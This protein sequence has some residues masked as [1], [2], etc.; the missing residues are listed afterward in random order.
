M[1]DDDDSAV[2]NMKGQG[3]SLGR[4]LGKQLRGA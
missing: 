2:P 4:N 1:L 3:L